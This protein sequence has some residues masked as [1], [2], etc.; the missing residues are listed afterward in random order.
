M[1]YDFKVKFE[2]AHVKLI[3]KS[4]DILKSLS[5]G[6]LTRI[7]S[8]FQE[9]KTLYTEYKL[10]LPEIFDIRMKNLH[11]FLSNMQYE[12]YNNKLLNVLQMGDFGFLLVDIKQKFI[13]TGIIIK[14]KR[15]NKID[16]CLP[17]EELQIIN[18][19]LRVYWKILVG[20]FLVINEFKIH[21]TS[22]NFENDLQ[23]ASLIATNL[24]DDDTCFSINKK[25]INRKAKWAYD[26]CESID[27]IG[28]DDII[29]NIGTL[30]RLKIIKN[31]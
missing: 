27:N 11:S 29:K 2:I 28:K 23:T 1:F 8:L 21:S 24:V 16:I 17:A 9:N 4:L 20:D 19:A 22:E 3:S 26:V 30:P 7:E 13:D 31:G 25:Y 6:E 15:L 10:D 18:V 12:H 5:K 14:K